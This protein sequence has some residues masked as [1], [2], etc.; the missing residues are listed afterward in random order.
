MD[1]N[2]TRWA[3]ALA[4]LRWKKKSKRRQ[5]GETMRQYWAQ[6]TPAQRKEIM[7]QRLGE[8]S[9]PSPKGL[10]DSTSD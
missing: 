1:E 10:P 4:N 6:F 7:R 2:K 9:K 8:R 5:H 3:S